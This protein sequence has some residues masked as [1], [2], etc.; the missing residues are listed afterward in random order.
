M[1]DS[2]PPFKRK[3]PITASR[4]PTPK[5]SG[6]DDEPFVPKPSGRALLRVNLTALTDNY[7]AIKKLCA[8]KGRPVVVSAVVKA[9]AYGLGAKHVARALY[10]A[11]CRN[12]FV[13][14]A[15]EGK[16]LRDHIGKTPSIYVLNGPTPREL[17]LFYAFKLKP[18]INNMAQAYLWDQGLKSQEARPRCAIHFDTGI[19]RMGF[20]GSELDALRS[21][22]ALVARLNPDHL[23]SHLACA[24]DA[25]NR[26]NR[27]QREMFAAVIKSFP[28]VPLSLSNSAGVYLGA[29]FH[30]D[31]VRPGCALYGLAATK[32]PAQETTR[33]VV[34]I[35][36]PILQV[37]ELK[38]G[39]SAGYGASFIAPRDMTIATIGVGYADGLPLVP[40]GTVIGR[41]D[42]QNLSTAGRI[43]MD[44][45]ILDMT[46]TRRPPKPGQVVTLLADQ[47]QPYADAAGVLNYQMLTML[48]S[49]FFRS[50]D[51]D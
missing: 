16:A 12:F 6:G 9:D 37:N 20:H 35:E 8:R 30:F 36:A 2:R 17:P 28:P 24:P 3:S 21:D 26:K 34:Q 39:E 45:T 18:V 5:K 51:K 1:P 47:L 4:P 44:L 50:Y 19:N 41:L 22:T 25:D 11:G 32:T 33:P 31:M 38:K 13:S 48:G 27:K 10:G 7:E 43:S 14:T 49:R 42:K 29:D 15:H 23:M 40:N 46:G